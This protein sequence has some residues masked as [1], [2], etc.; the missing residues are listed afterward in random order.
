MGKYNVYK[1]KDGRFEG[2]IYTVF[3]GKRSYRS[4]YGKTYEE[5][6][7]K[8]SALFPA[9]SLTDVTVNQLLDRWLSSRITRIKKSTFA[10][11]HMKLNKHILPYFSNV[12]SNELSAVQVNEFINKKISEGLSLRYISDM[13]VILKSAFRYAAR[14]FR[15]VNPLDGFTFQRSIRSE[16]KMLSSDEQKKLIKRF[17]ADP[18]RTDV[19][20]VLSLYTGLRIGEVCALKWSDIDLDKHILTVNHTIQRIQ[21]FDGG[22]KTKLVITDP[23]SL[24]SKRSIP[25]PDGIYPL[26]KRFRRDNNSFVLSGTDKPVEPRTMQN[27]FA[28]ILRKE[29]L[30]RVHYHSLRHAFAT[31]AVELGFDIKT[32]SEIL[33]H[34]SVELTLNLYVHSSL[35]RKRAF[36]NLM[37]V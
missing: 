20:I 8:I 15:I 21:N 29:K 4:F 10:N 14:S 2:R 35:E 28:A 27:R 24:H 11:Y 30:P 25:I 22:K 7:K 13:I 33:G 9:A 5:V 26:L 6:E 32:L 1:R 34:S 18:T 19:G 16:I 12:S 36:M 37:T 31:R 3:E 17:S 23:K